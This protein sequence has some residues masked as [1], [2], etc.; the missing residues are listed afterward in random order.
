M[1]RK[2]ISGWCLL[3][4]MLV[5][6]S[7]AGDNDDICPPENSGKDKVHVMF[8]IAMD[9]LGKRYAPPSR[10]T[11][12]EDAKQAA[13]EYENR[14]A[15]DKLQVL[16]YDNQN[17]LVGEVEN[18][19]YIRHDGVYNNV[20][21]VLGELTLDKLQIGKDLYLQG[22]MVVLANQ[23]T[24]ITGD[25][26]KV[27]ANMD[28]LDNIS[29][30]YDKD[31]TAMM[32]TPFPMWGIHAIDL[33]LA[34][35]KRNDAG[36]IYLLR[37]QA[38][39]RVALSDEVKEAYKLT[40]VAIND[41]NRQGYLVPN[42]YSP[43]NETIQLNSEGSFHEFSSKAS[44]TLPFKEEN[45]NISQFAYMPEYANIGNN[46]PA[47]LNIE[48]VRKFDNVAKTYTLELKNY[49]TNS[50]LNIVRNTIYNFTIT[51]I[52]DKLDVALYYQVMGWENKGGDIQFD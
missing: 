45:P 38:K 17:K 32:T 37:T 11:W 36:I 46:A 20:Y 10:G 16:I 19:T 1:I 42:G 5:A 49:Q 48:L 26:V 8:T 33:Q 15:P 4:I 21:D 29:Y 35:G 14:I 24:P 41:Y 30:T 27:G 18:L 43:H 12:E 39:V 6:T 9:N 47:K 28:L 40:K 2:L 52:T 13:S 34:P 3:A 7:C 22:K 44:I 51:G 25:A 31:G 23:E 50:P